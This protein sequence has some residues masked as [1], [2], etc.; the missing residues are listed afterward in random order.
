MLVV[1]TYDLLIWLNLFFTISEIYWT[2]MRRESK[3][4]DVGDLAKKIDIKKISLN[5]PSNNKCC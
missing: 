3:D 1:G 4:L 2:R 5:S